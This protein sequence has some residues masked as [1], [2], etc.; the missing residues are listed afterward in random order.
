[1]K[2]LFRIFFPAF[3]AAFALASCYKAPDDEDQIFVIDSGG[4]GEIDF[5]EEENDPS[6][7]P[8]G[9]FDYASL[10]VM[11]HP[12]LLI[13]STGFVSL[14]DKVLKNP[15]SN[16]TLVRAH[17]MIMKLA[18]ASLNSSSPISYKFDASG[19][20]IMGMSRRALERIFSCSYAY[21]MTGRGEYLT[22]VKADM[23]TV[24]SFP[25]WNGISVFLDASEMATAVAIGYDWCYYDLPLSLR[26]Q[27][28]TALVDFCLSI[29]GDEHDYPHTDY[30]WNQVSY[31]GVVMSSLALYEKEKDL[32]YRKIEEALVN[33]A[34]TIPVTYS[35]DGNYPEGY[36]YWSYGTHFQVLILAA[37]EKVFGH[38]GGLDQLADLRKTAE[39]MLFM[40]GPTEE[41]FNYSD[42][43]RRYSDPQ[44]C[45]WWFAWKYKDISMLYNEQRLLN[46]YTESDVTRLLPMCALFS[47]GLDFSK[48]IEPPAKHLWSGKGDTPVVLVHGDWS[49]TETDSFLGVKGGMAKTNHGHMDAGSFVFDAF[50]KRWAEDLMVPEYTSIEIPITAAGGNFWDP[51]QNSMRWDVFVMTNYA[52]NTLT[53][54]G[55]KHNVGGFAT[56]ER[57]IDTETEKG[58]V[59]NIAPALGGGV[60]KALRTVKLVGYKE[61][62]VIDEITASSSRPAE[63]Q[64]RM[65]TRSQ[66][67]MQSSYIE[68]S[69]PDITQKM[70]LSASSSVSSIIPQ[71][72]TRPAHFDDGA[73][74]WDLSQDGKTIVGH[75]FTV[76]A[77]QSVTVTTTLSPVEQ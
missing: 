10:A 39:W 77:G 47:E 28:H 9:T 56:L 32:C 36:S 35:P 55:E 25:N 33:N 26:R 30:N 17:N 14:K 76:P 57:V 67:N 23:Q 68:L 73:R 42:C 71:M 64:W 53:V 16:A 65:M 27:A 5:K 66:A 4:G 13:D 40:S 45:M 7:D 50:G 58:G 34:R 38:T 75:R 8:A 15:E 51:G 74:T 11:R 49:F 54:N 63:V 72:M 61:L 70:R 43:T 22:K 31:G 60:S 46:N 59:F 6:P 24:C 29:T 52:H 37:L 18:D 41:V 3:I 44:Y 12:R 62:V 2:A 21:R 19:R 69:F 1:M 20:R 48:P